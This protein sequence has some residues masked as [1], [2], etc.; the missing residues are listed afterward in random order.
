MTRFA[1]SSIFICL[2]LVFFGAW[3]V[4]NCGW[5]PIPPFDAPFYLLGTVA[6]VQ[7]IFLSTCVLITQKRMAD[8]SEKRAEL[9]Y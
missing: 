2:Q 7:A 4:I 8:L 6:G 9:E 3:F 5:T 1:G